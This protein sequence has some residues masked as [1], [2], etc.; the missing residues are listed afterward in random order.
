[1][2]KKFIFM[3]GPGRSGTSIVARKLAGHESVVTFQDVEMKVFCEPGGLVDLYVNLCKIYSPTRGQHAL[4]VFQDVFNS[5]LEGR[6]QQFSLLDYLERREADEA[7]A[8]FVGSFVKSGQACPV[9]QSKF[10][11]S[12]FRFL[13]DL[14]QAGFRDQG[15]G[16]ECYFLEKTPHNLLQL[17]F[18]SCLVPNSKFIHVMRDPR[19]IAFSLRRMSWGPGELEQCMQWVANYV[20]AWINVEAWARET[21]VEVLSLF[22][23]GISA[24]PG[25]AMEDVTNYLGVTLKEDLF[26]DIKI[27]VLN[28]WVAKCSP[29]ELRLLHGG[30]AGVSAK[31]GYSETEVGERG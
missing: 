28:G 13:S 6:F 14:V 19:S 12:A 16:D 29:E 2:I 27:D 26:P 21:G 24:D 25:K 18:L 1:M 30:L 9:T 4:R 22:A 31:L 7:L 15:Y 23:E 10:F 3:G 20:D 5:V 8:R 17:E 11:E